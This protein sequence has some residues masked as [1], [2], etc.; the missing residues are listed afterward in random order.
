[1]QL[2]Q[3]S[4]SSSVKCTHDGLI[5][6][7]YFEAS[8]DNHWKAPLESWEQRPASS[9]HSIHFN[10]Y[11]LLSSP[12]IIIGKNP[13]D[14]KDSGQVEKGAIEDEMVGWHYQL[15]G[16]ELEQIPGDSEQGIL[17]C[18]PRGLKESDTTEWLN[19]KKITVTAINTHSCFQPGQCIIPAWEACW[20]ILLTNFTYSGSE[21]VLSHSWWAAMLH[22]VFK[23]SFMRHG[24]NTLC[25]VLGV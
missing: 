3:V 16:R 6:P 13:N 20:A 23:Q 1:M 15:N 7:V 18:S 25:M 12:V 8:W 9:N 4:V 19:N 21:W 22:K 24:L 11:V 10:Y 2:V 17:C 14:G 5:L